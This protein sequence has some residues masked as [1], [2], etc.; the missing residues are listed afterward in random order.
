MHITPEE[1]NNW[2]IHAGGQHLHWPE[3]GEDL[4]VAGLLCGE[5]SGKRLRLFQRWREAKVVA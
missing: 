2:E 1:R 5:K 4:S 3:L